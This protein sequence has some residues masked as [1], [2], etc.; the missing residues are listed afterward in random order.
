MAGAREDKKLVT[1][2]PQI[3]REET[4][5]SA[6]EMRA[7]HPTAPGYRDD[8]VPEVGSPHP[9][10]GQPGVPKVWPGRRGTHGAPSANGSPI[11]PGTF[12]DGE[13]ED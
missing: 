10:G 11:Q 2:W 9:G 4:D 6:E 12:F 13:F 3:E 5:R 7:G 8:Y 1:P